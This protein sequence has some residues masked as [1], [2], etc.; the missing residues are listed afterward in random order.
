MIRQVTTLPA[1]PGPKSGGKAR[2]PA[3]PAVA[4]FTIGHS[5]H[6]AE[7]FLH[8]LRTHGIRQ[9]VDVRRFP[10]SRR[11]PHFNQDALARF[12][13]N[14]RIGYRHMEALGGRRRVRPGSANAGWR[15]AAFR[16]YADYMQ[17]EP[18]RGALDRLIG[19]ACDRRTAILCAEA[20]PW[21]CHRWLIA[22]AL[23]ARDVDVRHII[24]PSAPRPHTLTP[25]AVRSKDHLTYPAP[26]E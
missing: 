3:A 12:L 23:V 9:V 1:R 20:V 10:G 11:F 19:I 24:S 25:M 21:R 14:H 15:N 13:R 26:A 18:F 8:L 6:S 17:T 16:G 22:D 5:T 4:V 2:C 7:E